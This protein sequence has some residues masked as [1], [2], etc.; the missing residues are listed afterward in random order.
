MRY[1]LPRFN[2]QN[3]RREASLQWMKDNAHEFSD[4][5]DKAAERAMS[6]S[7]KTPAHAK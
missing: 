6:K 2:G 1:V 4:I 7:D 5:R 3:R